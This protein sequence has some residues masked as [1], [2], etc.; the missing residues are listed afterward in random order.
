MEVIRNIVKCTPEQYLEL[1]KNGEVEVN[2]EIKTYSENTLYDTGNLELLEWYNK[3]MEAQHKELQP[4]HT[5]YTMKTLEQE[6]ADIIKENPDYQSASCVGYRAYLKK[7]DIVGIASKYNNGEWFINGKRVE[8]N[9]SYNGSGT[10][11]VSV[12]GFDTKHYPVT[13]GATPSYYPYEIYI[14]NIGLEPEVASNYYLYANK[15]TTYGFIL[16]YNP[17]GCRVLVANGTTTFSQ[18]IPMAVQEVSSN[19]ESFSNFT[20][21]NKN[22]Y[23]NKISLPNCREISVVNSTP[24]VD[25]SGIKTWEFGKLQKLSATGNTCYIF[26]VVNTVLIPNTVKIMSQN[27]CRNITTLRLE[28]N[29]ATSIDNNWY[30]DTAPTNFSMAKNWNASINIAKAAGNWTKDRFLELFEDLVPVDITGVGAAYAR[31]LTIPAAIYDEL[32]EEEYAIAEDKGWILGG[33]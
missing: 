28:C 2:G 19:C 20:G 21:F 25:N 9:Y 1:L 11:L 27:V 33:A 24:F 23:V 18:K 32:T 10:E 17:R 7:G 29:E 12:V 4:A 5:P 31:E 30:K 3:M 16:P 22:G 26:N 6:I 14:K 8:A 15:I 13:L